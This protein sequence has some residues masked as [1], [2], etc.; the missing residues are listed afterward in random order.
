M[1]H[2]VHVR[3]C[4]DRGERVAAVGE[5]AR[6]PSFCAVVGV[7]V[8]RRRH[9]ELLERG[10]SSLVAEAGVEPVEAGDP[11]R[12][13]RGERARFDQD[14]DS[15]VIA[16]RRVDATGAG[17]RLV[18]APRAACG[19]DPREVLLEHRG[20]EERV[21]VNDPAKEPEELLARHRGD[22]LGEL[23]RVGA[24]REPAHVADLDAVH[25][26]APFGDRL[27]P[28]ARQGRSDGQDRG[29]P[30]DRGAP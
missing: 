30:V 13:Y 5:R 18:V 7:F 24:A 6:K 19:L 4:R 22:F 17:V 8:E 11:E 12:A 14:L 10:T 29:E 23:V 1:A 26:R 15:D 9:P 21:F 25:G 20:L 3:L 27:A 2:E 16:R 28:R